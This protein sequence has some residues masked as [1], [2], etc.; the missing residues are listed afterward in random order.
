MKEA[1]PCLRCGGAMELGYVVDR[2]N[3]GLPGTQ[4]WV[5][6]APER[7]FL[8]GLKLKGRSVL[9][10]ET[11]RCGGCGYLESYASTPVG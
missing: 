6:G 11:Y 8:A 5:E 10:V 1:F 7:S 9:A 4:I 2:G 3:E